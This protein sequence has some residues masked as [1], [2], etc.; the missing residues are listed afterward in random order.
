[1]SERS[2]DA[3]D[4]SLATKKLKVQD[5]VMRLSEACGVHKDGVVEVRE[6]CWCVC[7]TPL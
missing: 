6:M 7:E 1:M 2:A 5:P 4:N 3:A